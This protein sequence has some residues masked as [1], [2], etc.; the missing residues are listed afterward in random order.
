MAFLDFLKDRAKV[1]KIAWLGFIASIVFI[2]I[3]FF[4]MIRELF[5]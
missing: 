3:G 1:L 2:A 5:A 4:L